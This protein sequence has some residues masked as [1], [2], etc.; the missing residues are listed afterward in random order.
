MYSQHFGLS[1]DPF[2]I[3][4][5]P[6]YLFMS[7]R[8]REALA[9]LLYGVVGS[10]AA[11][12][13][14]GTGGGF[15]LLT[16]D[17]GTGK[18]TI[19][20]CFLE[21]IPAGCQVAYIFNPKLS[22]TELLQSICE[23]FHITLA[24]GASGAPS[25]KDYIDAL[26]AFLLQRHASGQSSV[27]II[28]EAQNLQAEVLEQLRLLTNLETNE[29]KLL[30][31][32]LIGQPEL[33]TL[34]ARPELEQLAQRV[35]ARF[36]LDA[37]SAAES[38]QYIAHRLAVA[39]HSGALPFDRPALQ[40]I[41]RLA[42][43]VPRRINLLCGRSLLGAWASGAA[44][45]NRRVVDKAASEV[46]GPNPAPPPLARRRSA[47][48]LGALGLAISA[49]LAGW[50]LWPLEPPAQPLTPVTPVTRVPAA[51]LA[52]LTPTPPVALRPSA[53]GEID[54]L[55][56][57][58]PRDINTAWR[59]LAS[60]WALPALADANAGDPCLALA[61]Q[62][63]QCYR[64]KQLSVPQLRQ[65]GRP[66]IL[67]LQGADGVPVYALLVGLGEQSATLQLGS[68]LQ[69]VRLVALGRL[70]RGD[71]ATFW[72]VPP[73][74]AAGLPEGSRGPAIDQL[75]TQLARLDGTPALSAGQGPAQLDAAL[76]ERVRAFQRAQGL[77]ADGQPGPMTFMQLDSAT[78]GPGPRLQTDPN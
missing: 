5:D 40:R 9:H 2:S 8:H 58:L 55:L 69:S 28:D 25:G 78:G 15:V 4:P 16:G 70:W 76:R 60:L 51:S 44:R 31:I 33:R 24:A 41:H 19:C 67:S 38:N 34:L 54:A 20:R 77:Q 18:T 66:G 3:A 39:G 49:A 50:L 17:I 71:F 6:R 65:L 21:Q 27:L 13:S 26:N 57:Q 36:H 68:S 14:S 59:A 37:L 32:V 73:G 30:Q 53:P 22:V 62:A 11:A 23:E 47:Y 61:P 52:A 74:Y 35:I 64:S 10:G 12:G 56:A 72:R 42:R 63:L 75:A 7:E 48:A 46:F 45:V 43:G 29:R 1:Q